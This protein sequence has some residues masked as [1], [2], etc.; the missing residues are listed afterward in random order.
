MFQEFN[1]VTTTSNFIKNLLISTYLPLIRTVRDFDYIIKDRLYVYKCEIIKCTKSGYLL[2]GYKNVKFDGD[3]AAYRVVTEYYFGERNDKLCT[4]YIS[5]SEGYDSITHERLGKYLRSLR[6]M[7][8]L[9]L[10]PLYNCFSNQILQAHHITSARVEK[11]ATDYNT[12]IYKVPIRFNTDYT[13]CMENLNIKGLLIALGQASLMKENPIY[14]GSLS[15]EAIIKGKLDKIN[16]L[17]NLSII[18]LDMKNIPSDLRLNAPATE[19]KITSDGKT[20]SGNAESFNIKLINPAATIFAKS[21]NANILSDV[22]E[23]TETPVTIEKINTTI[24]GKITNYLTEKIGLD[25]VS[26]GDIKSTLKGDMNIPKQTLNLVYQTTD[27]STIIIPMFDKSKLSFKGKIN[28][29]G[30][31]LNP[32]INGS[33]TVPSVSV[34]E[35]PVTMKDMDLKFQGTILHGSGMVKEF[36]SGGIK[37]QNLTSDFELKGMDFYLNNLKG[38]SFKGKVNGNIVYNLS[39]AKTKI[40]FK[41]S[42]LD[43]EEA[44][45]GAAG[46]KNALSGTLG[47]DTKLTLTVL[48]YNAMIKSMKGDLSFD[49]KKGAFGTIGRFEGFLGASNITQNYFLKNTVNAL[50]NAA[51]LA[52]TAQ[53]DV[54]DGRMTFSDGWANLNPIKSAG[55][56]L[57]Y[58]I[59][60]RYNIVNGTTNVNIL[61]RL[62]APMVAKL[63]ALGSLDMSDIIGDKAASVLKILTSNPQGEKTELIPALTNGSTNS[64]E[65]KVSFNGGVDSKSSVKS[66]KWLKNADMTNLQKQTAKDVVNSVKEAYKTDINTTKEEWNNAVEAEK[67][68][69]E[70]AKKQI[71]TTKEDF[72]NLWKSIKDISK[73]AENNQTTQPAVDT[74]ITSPAENKPSETVSQTEASAPVQE[75]EKPAEEQSAKE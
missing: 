67:K 42:G 38:E 39:N 43:A 48:E 41:G 57:C 60:G 21:I 69:I 70:D 53:F 7:Y 35:I 71:N 50:S 6:D 11:T 61:G 4:N 62:D 65:F 55:Q 68:K 46:I 44:I 56:S 29:T 28:I 3:R 14:S 32:V 36:A 10:M 30:S 1:K 26:T 75:N 8:D 20:L 40:V 22:I 37:A 74:K 31:M 72:Q 17:I 27:L 15:M 16:P 51:G 5:N 13:I 47:F 9:N 2:T 73:P 18:N 66:F 45:E 34:P 52:T 12:K 23:I 49:I 64:Q 58:Y 19:V 33:A 63:G 54:L 25:F 24:K 59:T